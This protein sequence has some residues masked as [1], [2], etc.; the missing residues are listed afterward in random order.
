MGALH[1]S[2]LLNLNLIFLQ[3]QLAEIKDIY[4]FMLKQTLKKYPIKT[5]YETV[6]SRLLEKKFDEGTLFPTGVAIPHAYL[7]DFRD[8]VISVLVPKVPISTEFGLIKIFFM[9]LACNEDNSLYL[10]ILQSVVM[11]SKDEKMFQN[12]LAARN[13]ADFLSLIKKSDFSVKRAMTVSDIMHNEVLTVSKELSLKKISQLFYEN[14]MS[15]FIVVDE[16]EKPI[17]EITLLDYM[18]AG[19]PAYTSFLNNLHFMKTLEPFEKLIKEENSIQVI[20]VM[21]PI[22]VSVTAQTSVFKAVF[23]MNKHKKYGLPVIE[24]QR[25]LGIITIKDIF[26]K[27]VKG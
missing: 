10:H 14:N 26:K 8:T 9:V 24:N 15:I 5:S 21:K 4:S 11:I 3:S 23:L 19:V 16:Y 27:V 25:L 17:G 12:L 18:M 2:S 7:D 1:L 22:E 20:N 13:T 6:M